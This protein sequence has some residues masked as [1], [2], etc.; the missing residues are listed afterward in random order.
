MGYSPP[1]V[2]MASPDTLIHVGGESRGVEAVRA[3]NPKKKIFLAAGGV[4]LIGVVAGVALAG[5]LTPKASV[6]SQDLVAQDL[7]KQLLE[8]YPAPKVD[9]K[10]F[11]EHCSWEFLTCGVKSIT[12]ETCIKAMNCEENC[13]K[14]EKEA[15][16]NRAPG[17]AYLCEMTYG[18]TSP[19]F[20][21]L[22]QCG[23]D[24]KCLPFY[25]TDGE[26]LA[27]DADALQNVTSL[28]QVEGDWWVIKG[29]NCGQVD[30]GTPFH[31]GAG[32][33]ALNPTKG[34]NF[35]GGYDWYPCQHERFVK[36]TGHD[37]P[38]PTAPWVNN[39]TYCG[40]AN[41]GL[42]ECNTTIIDTVANVTMCAPGVVCHN[43]TDAPLMPQ[44]EHW[45]IISWPHPDYMFT[46]WCGGTPLLPYNG[47]I[48]LSTQRTGKDMPAWVEE[49][50]RQTAKRFGVDWDQMC[51]STNEDCP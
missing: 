39:I 31:P 15:G 33:P 6:V 36:S 10:C 4:L 35:P 25:P 34:K 41:G 20:Q 23:R 51:P 24:H 19:A 37:F 46:I 38:N 50:F 1:T 9:V 45:R 8:D 18:Y 5:V 14:L 16:H 29:I 3:S 7:V 13:N 44:F 22:M 11:I 17:C 40:G 28:D 27:T 21:R 48:T 49:N 47:G 26:C 30:D 32:Y 2:L 43:Y 42:K 12:G